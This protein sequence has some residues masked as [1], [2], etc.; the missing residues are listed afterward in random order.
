MSHTAL[1]GAP[2]TYPASFVGP[3][4]VVIGEEVEFQFKV[5]MPVANLNNFVIRDELPAGIDCIE[6][7]D[8]DLSSGIY[9]SA[10]FSPGK[11]VVATCTDSL[12]E[13]NFGNEQLTNGPTFTFTASFIARVE[14]S[15][16]TNDVA[17]INAL[18]PLTIVNGG[19]STN[20]TL[21]YIDAGGTTVNIPLGPATLNVTEPFI[22]LD[23]TFTVTEADARDVLTVTVTA[24][25]NGEAP[26]YNLRIRDDLAAL[27]N[28]TYLGFPGG[29]DPP[30]GI[31]VGANQPIFS[32]NT[33]VAAGGSKSFTF[34]VT[35]GDTVQPLELLDNTITADWTSL[36]DNT[37]ALNAGGTIG[38][39]GAAD[40]MRVGDMLNPG[41]D[42]TND[43]EAT[44]FDDATSV[45]AVTI[46]KTDLTPGV[47]P[48]IGARKNFQVV[49]TI[50][51]GNT[52][53]LKIT[54]N[55]IF[56]PG[57]SFALENN[58]GFDIT[59]NFVDIVSI[60]G[61]AVNE[62]SFN[63][64]E[65]ADNTINS[66]VW[67]IG[68]I[69]TEK[70]NDPTNNSFSPRIIINYFARID[71]DASIVAGDN[72]QNE[73]TLEYIDGE[74]GV[75]VVS[76][77]TSSAPAITVL[78]PSL[79]A[80]KV[81]TNQTPGKLP[82]DLPDG[83]DNI[84]YVITISNDAASSTAFDVNIVDTLPPEL[85][86]DAAFTPTVTIGAGAPI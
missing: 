76:P 64:A 15:S 33:P 72:M 80:T 30:D 43:F 4:D 10:G 24:T 86:L 53:D 58:P 2:I 81:F 42:A 78:E 69:I 37:I 67:D 35:V 13:W 46:D 34:Q 65:P 49:L 18:N 14:N 32:W 23:K 56:A 59:Y 12:V 31:V 1:V 54:D 19:A 75:T 63:A 45:P 6:A 73:A 41:G 77:D 48:A 52:N 3:Q 44:F 39:D 68:D 71:N 17:P 60:N 55:L 61:L 82:G 38:A 26:A 50:P 84:E 27:G 11:T 85:S 20:A 25:N 36:P 7:P 22:V 79:T 21:S 40:G 51:E 5:V 8:I 62:S 70:E 16:A 57:N 74:T 9:A 29:A 66:A 83:G 28:L 47:I